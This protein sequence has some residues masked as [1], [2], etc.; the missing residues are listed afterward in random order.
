MHQTAESGKLMRSVVLIIMMLSGVLTACVPTSTSPSTEVIA[1]ESFL[2]DLTRDVAGETLPVDALIPAGIELHGYQP[3]TQDIARLSR[4]KVII[5]NGAGLEP[6]L[7]EVVTNASQNAIIIEAAKGIPL[8][9]DDPHV[10]LDP[11]LV[12]T[13]IENITAGL[14]VYDENHRAEFLQNAENTKHKLD[15]LD[16]WIKQ[17]VKA[18]PQSRRIL[19]TNHES[20]GYFALRYGFTLIGSII[21]SADASAEPTAQNLATLVERINSSRAPAIFLEAGSNVQLAEQLQKETSIKVIVGMYTHST[22]ANAPTYFEMMR[23]NV[24]KIV[25]ALE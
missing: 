22:D 11:I 4:A 21:P 17:Q 1:V 2:A 16:I 10:W 18:I 24:Q 14:S 12:K 9:K 19:V 8:I 7:E 5:L 3:S 6:W 23:S 25:S 20:L 13:Y 15:E